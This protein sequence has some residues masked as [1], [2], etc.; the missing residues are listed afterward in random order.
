MGANFREASVPFICLCGRHLWH[1][2]HLPGA[3]LFMKSKDE[4]LKASLSKLEKVTA[5]MCGLIIEELGW[6]AVFYITAGIT[7]LWVIIWQVRIMA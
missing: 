1:H 6:E 4:L 5:Q 7:I 3:D 2:H